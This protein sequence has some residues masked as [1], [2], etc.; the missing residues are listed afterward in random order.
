MLRY[1]DNMGPLIYDEMYRLVKYIYI[2]SMGSTLCVVIYLLVEFYMYNIY[3]YGYVGY[4][5]ELVEKIVKPDYYGE[6]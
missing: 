6:F 3:I 4:Y 1:F 2:D 5:R